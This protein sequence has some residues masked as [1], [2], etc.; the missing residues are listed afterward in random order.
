MMTGLKCTPLFRCLC[1]VCMR[2]TF[3]LGFLVKALVP[4]LQVSLLDNGIMTITVTETELVTY[5]A[6]SNAPRKPSLRSL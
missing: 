4:E 6:M 2:P 1:V 5:R 3:G